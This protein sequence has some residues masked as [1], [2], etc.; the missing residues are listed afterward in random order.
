MAA[1]IRELRTSSG[2]TQA[3][4][5][6]RA[7]V[8]RQLVAA[9]EAG[10]HS[11]NVVAAL[12]L[13]R[14][15]GRSVEELFAEPPAD[16]V[17]VTGEALPT[18]GSPVAVARVG[19]TL[20][21]VP[22]AHGVVSSERW[23]LADAVTAGGSVSMLT[24]GTDDGVVIAGCDPA[25][26]I[27][28][29][30]VE[31]ATSHRVVTAH[32]STGRAIGALADG[33]VH[34]VVVHAPAGAMPAPPVPVRR[35]HLARWQ[36]GVASGRSS[37]VPS[38][39]EIAERRLRVVQRDDGAGTQMAFARALHKVGSS[40]GVPGPRGDGHVDVARRVASGAAAGLTME[41]AARSFGL[42]FAPL[43]E[44]EVEVWLDERWASLPAAVAAMETF[45]GT[46]V[47]TRLEL[48]GGYDLAGHGDR[49]A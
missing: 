21:A 44:H 18:D 48:I 35:W 15:V 33:R 10:R 49:V 7:G 28:A 32:A 37:G 31:R 25:L 27:V 46:A 20:V 36:V 12:A 38:V 23:A 17:S 22:A 3:E 47:R 14:A 1:S 19:D 40:S 24:D 26:G 42:G 34:A 39:E 11:P 8:S 2:W 29:A 45:A 9:V 13:A 4:L 30:L 16:A 41:A 5:A 43:E 6:E